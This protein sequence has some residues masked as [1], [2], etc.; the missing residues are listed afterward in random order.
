MKIKGFKG[1][2]GPYAID[3][4]NIGTRWNIEDSEGNSIALAAQVVKDKDYVKRDAN[5]RLL[6]SSYEMAEILVYIRNSIAE[7]GSYTPTS[8]DS[9]DEIL[10]KALGNEEFK[11]SGHGI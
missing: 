2:E 9:L 1:I 7:C 8:L 3:I 5:T 10:K 4:H 11:D 6:A